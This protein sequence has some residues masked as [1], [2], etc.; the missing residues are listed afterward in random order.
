MTVRGRIGLL[1]LLVACARA[2]QPASDTATITA[3]E[4]EIITD[5]DTLGPQPQPPA[6]QLIG[7]EPFWGLRIDGDG[8]TFTT[9]VDTA[10]ER[11]PA[12]TP[13]M[14]GDTLRWNSLDRAGRM[15]E[16]LVVPATC[17]DGMSDKQW[18]HRAQLT[19][20]RDRYEGCAERRA[21]GR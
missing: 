8:M 5:A 15:V 13:V 3:T 1:L 4:P 20:G 12:S 9:P 14:V 16:A 2:E 7:T 19:I 11:F 21:S 17:S 6:F 10:G 18:S